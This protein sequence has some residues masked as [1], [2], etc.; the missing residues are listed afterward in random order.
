MSWIIAIYQQNLNVEASASPC[1]V[2]W[3]LVRGS[4]AYTPLRRLRVMRGRTDSPPEGGGAKARLTNVGVDNREI[5][6]KFKIEILLLL[7]FKLTLT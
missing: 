7:A 4:Y 2:A 6:P 5:L 1:L 3:C